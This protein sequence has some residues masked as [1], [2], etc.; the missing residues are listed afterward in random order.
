MRSRGRSLVAALTTIAAGAVVI[1]GPGT[2]CSSFTAE[3][4]VTS[5]DFCFIF[6]CQNGAWGGT[7][8]PCN[9]ASPTFVDCPI[10]AP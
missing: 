10:D 2:S 1:S 5:T 7:L 3:T 6:D 4:L 8:D 9:A